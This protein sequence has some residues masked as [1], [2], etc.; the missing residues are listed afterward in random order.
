M[1]D[2]NDDTENE[3]DSEENV[4]TKLTPGNL[5][6]FGSLNLTFTLTL[7]KPD[8]KKYKI[9]F[10]TLKTLQDLKFILEH[11]KFIKRIDITS[12]NSV[13]NILL[14]INKSAKKVLKIGYVSYK[15]I[16]FKEDQEDFK[17]FIDKVT[18]FNGLYLA[19]C[20]VCKCPMGIELKIIYENKEKKFVICG[21]S[22]SDAIKEE[23]EE[24]ANSGESDEEKNKNKNNS[25]KKPGPVVKKA[26]ENKYEE[27]NPFI[28]I[29]KDI[30]KLLIMKKK[31]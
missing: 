4:S 7:K 30:V 5:L 23:K 24:E 31:K 11:K 2:K 14:N 28:S 12:P 10:D 17:D 29:T 9:K 18:K 1:T 8:I 25:N 26:K 6:A 21:Q 13:M 27:T 15:K 3:S 16:S 20:D 19:S 22:V